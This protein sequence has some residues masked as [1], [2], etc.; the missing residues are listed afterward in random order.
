MEIKIEH[1]ES[2]NLERLHYCVES[3]AHLI[4]RL[5]QGTIAPENRDTLLAKYMEEYESYFT[6]YSK[7]K[8]AV[9]KKYRPE[10]AK[11]WTLDFETDTLTFEV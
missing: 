1:E 10:G 8:N 4:E 3:R 7:A 6:E 5:Y 11:S 9:E 2:K